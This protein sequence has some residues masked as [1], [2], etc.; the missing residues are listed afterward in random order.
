MLLSGDTVIPDDEDVWLPLLG[1][2]L[3]IVAYKA[4]TQVLLTTDSTREFIRDSSMGVD[5]QFVRRAVLP[6]DDAQ[7][8]DMDEGLVFAVSR[9]I[10]SSV[11]REKFGIHYTAAL[12][13]INNYNESILAHTEQVNMDD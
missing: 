1:Y 8:I 10:A 7:E 11:S 2:A 12:A 3:E 13:I 4:N 5:G 9:L 6:S